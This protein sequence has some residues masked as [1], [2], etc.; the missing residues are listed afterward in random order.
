MGERSWRE[1]SH[2]EAFPAVSA[3]QD[4]WAGQDPQVIAWDRSDD[5]PVADEPVVPVDEPPVPEPVVPGAV[6]NPSSEP[7]IIAHAV[8]VILGALVTAGWLTIPDPLINIIGSVVAF[9]LATVGAILARARVAPVHGG[10]W[11]TIEAYVRD[12]VGAELARIQQ[13]NGTTC[14]SE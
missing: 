5:E 14:A 12:L 11:A 8:T 6:L 13:R 10:W 1:H 7:V 4:T 3:A 2:T 9:V